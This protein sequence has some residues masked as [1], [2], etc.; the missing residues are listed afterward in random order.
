[1][2]A[3]FLDGSAECDTRREVLTILTSVTERNGTVRLERVDLDDVDL[4]IDDDELDVQETFD[5]KC[6]GESLRIIDD[7][8]DN[9]GGEVSVADRRRWNLPNGRARSTCSIIPGM[10][11]STPSE[12]PSTSTSVPSI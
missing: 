4:V 1:M 7:G 6:Y 9:L 3:E 12:M 8:I 5:V 2:I 11:T 10:I